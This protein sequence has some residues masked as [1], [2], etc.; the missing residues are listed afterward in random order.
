MFNLLVQVLFRKGTYISP[1]SLR[2]KNAG[3]NLTLQKKP[4]Y[5]LYLSPKNSP[6]IA[7]DGEDRS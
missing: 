4:K 3:L 2:I 7:Q 1:Y 5:L 6:V